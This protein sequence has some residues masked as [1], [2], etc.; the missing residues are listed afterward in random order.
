MSQCIC[1]QYKAGAEDQNG[2]SCSRRSHTGVR[3]ALL[4]EACRC[5]TSIP[6]IMFSCTVR[7]ADRRRSSNVDRQLIRSNPRRSPLSGQEAFLIAVFPAWPARFSERPECS[8]IRTISERT[9]HH[10]ILEGIAHRT[11]SNQV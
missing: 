7:D 10:T 3:W 5:F 2:R 9:V 8:V 6:T 11:T 4:Q 1:T